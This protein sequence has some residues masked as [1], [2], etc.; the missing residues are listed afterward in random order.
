M[1]ELHSS[2]CPVGVRPVALFSV[3]LDSRLMFPGSEY[4]EYNRTRQKPHLPSR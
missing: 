1:H 3:G 4:N 2:H